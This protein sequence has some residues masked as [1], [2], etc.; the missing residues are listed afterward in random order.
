MSGECEGKLLRI[1]VKNF[2]VKNLFGKHR[3]NFISAK[4]RQNG[5][6]KLRDKERQ[7]MIYVIKIACW[8]E[9]RVFLAIRMHVEDPKIMI[10]MYS[11]MNCAQNVLSLIMTT[12]CYY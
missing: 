1:R 4:S 11:T 10:K 2:A 9:N 8:L 6:R 12:A 3:N 7:T 5:P